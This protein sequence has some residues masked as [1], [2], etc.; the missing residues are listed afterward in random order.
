MFEQ[1]LS[2]KGIECLKEALPHRKSSLIVWLFT[3][4]SCFKKVNDGRIHERRK[5]R[6]ALDTIG[7]IGQSLANMIDMVVGL[8]EKGGNMVII[9]LIVNGIAFAP[10]FDQA[11][12]P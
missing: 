10:W 7:M 9:H 5:P 12:I 11:T 1:L 3:Y 2:N 4:A 6:T 8:F